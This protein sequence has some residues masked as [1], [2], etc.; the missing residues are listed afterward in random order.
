MMEGSRVTTR[1][2]GNGGDQKFRIAD[3]ELMD[4]V[5]LYNG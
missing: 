2:T 3:I 1:H 5:Y 4:M